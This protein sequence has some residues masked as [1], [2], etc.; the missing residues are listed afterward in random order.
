MG[1]YD[2]TIYSIIKR[3]AL[4]FGDRPAQVCGDVSLSHREFLA[5]VDR[6]AAGLWASGLRK[7]DRIAVLSQ[8]NL[9]YMDIYGAAAR[10]GA[11]VAPI[12]WRLTA[13]EVSYMVSDSEAS[14]VIVEAGFFDIANE[15]RTDLPTVK[16]WY[17][18]GGEDDTHRPISALYLDEEVPPVEVAAGD[19]YVIMYTAAVDV[20]P[21]GA[22]LSHE[23]L[24]ASN[25]QYMY[26]WRLTEDDVHLSLLPL[27]HVTGFGMALAAMQAGGANVLQPR[28][29][30]DSALRL[31]EK[32][33]VTFFGG[34]PP[35]F[36]TLVGQAEQGD[37][38]CSS[39][40]LVGGLDHPDVITR[41]QEK[42]G[43]AFWA[44]FGQTET[45][46]LP[47]LTQYNL[48]PG[49]A[50]YVGPMCE[51]EIMDEAGTILPRGDKGE[52]V[53]RGPMVFKGYWKR[54]QDNEFTFRF[55]WHH[56]GDLGRLDEDGFLWYMGR[57]PYK[58]LIKPGGEN[59][60]PAEVERVILEHPDVFECS[61][62]GVPDEEWGEAVKAV[63]VLKEG[64]TMKEADLID[65]VASRIARYKKP[66]FVVFAPELPKKEDGS[67]DRD[68]VKALYGAG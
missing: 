42:V 63:C 37:Y 68:Q 4:V 22:V 16:S 10:I 61:V 38:D 41:F 53:C 2:F 46:G 17:G 3:N 20:Q 64:Q 50:G 26:F 28:F 44:A 9:E 47:T 40:R 29:D 67:V 27:F 11:V 13:E 21:R 56:T 6:L 15:I 31:I 51:V 14:A 1:V 5:R 66:K 34:F 8:N 39:L 58:E 54:P 45:S 32:D 25:C 57:V 12:N 49:S 43:G 35:M 23:G 59:V 7:G 30:P 62:I 24:I 36:E 55:G 52:I 65:Y 48:R 33:K 19:D 18:L 60:Y